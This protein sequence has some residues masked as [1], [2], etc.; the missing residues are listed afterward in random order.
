[1]LPKNSASHTP[2]ILSHTLTYPYTYPLHIPPHIHPA[3]FF[4]VQHDIYIYI[5]I[6]ITLVLVLVEWSPQHRE[7]QD[8]GTVYGTSAHRVADD[9][10]AA[11]PT[12]S[13]KA[14]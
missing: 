1:M 14:Y 9:D 7:R 3:D 5:Y 10:T 11:Q 2:H 8:V 12:K 4:Q 13:T 6:Y